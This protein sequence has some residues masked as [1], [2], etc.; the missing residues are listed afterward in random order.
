MDEEARALRAAVEKAKTVLVASEPLP[1]GDAFGSELA[2]RFMIESAFGLA[3]E[4][5][6]ART[7]RGPKHVALLNERGTPERYAFLDGSA[8]RAPG[9]EDASGFD[10]AILVDGGEERL[11]D[12]VRAVFARCKERVYIDHHRAG[13][14][15][16]YD[17]RLVDPAAASTTEVIM[18]I[19]ESPAW[20]DV[21][22]T[23]PLA[24]ALYVGLI[25]D[26]GSFMY[27][28]TTPRTHRVAARLLEAGTRAVLI[29]ERV[30]L[31]MRLDDLEL[32]A[33]VVASVGKECGGKLLVGV[34]TLAMLHGRDPTLVGYDKVVTP[35][36][37]VSGTK[38]TLLLREMEPGVWKLSFRSRGEVDVSA[39]A[40][41]VDPG[42]G[43]HARAAGCSLN[44]SLE[45]VRGKAVAALARAIERSGA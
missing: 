37:F 33:A 7:G 25:S 17:V 26:T 11:G 39:V 10:L 41:E 16:R 3:R 21:K 27:S 44:G 9:P 20:S 35:L 13:S 40:R 32:L 19:L 2:L 24:E 15:A 30:L 45:L 18:M 28:L 1:D 22:L 36:A 6:D 4:R 43:G 12:A 14:A 38:A 8:S 23:R 42:G 29:G 34:L 5:A 31:D